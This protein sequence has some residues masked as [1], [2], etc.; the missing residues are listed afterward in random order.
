[1]KLAAAIVAAFLLA[2]TPAAAKVPQAPR[3]VFGV[4]WHD[5]ATS[6]AQLDALT[7]QPRTRAVPLGIAASYRG[8]SPGRGMRA[9]FAIGENGTAIRFVD[10]EHMRQEARVD[11]GCPG[12]PI[13]WEDASRLVTMCVDAAASVV[14]IDP[15]RKKVVSR[16][17]LRG[18]LLGAD[19]TSGA[20]VGLLAPLDGIGPVRLVVANGAGV[21]RIVALRSRRPEDDR[22]EHVA[23]PFRD[24]RGRAPAERTARGRDSGERRGD[25][26][27]PDDPRRSVAAACVAC[28]RSG[29]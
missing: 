5:R 28:P 17:R 3:A 12:G 8:R 23:H 11:L 25:R 7:L 21:T 2:A 6:V 26:R 22:S 29:A 16:K 27:R 1:M 14:V 24:A 18:T 15:V 9:A 10:L 4:I 20:L 19:A 13:L